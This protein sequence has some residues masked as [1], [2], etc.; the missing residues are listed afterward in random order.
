M[1]EEGIVDCII[2]LPTN[3]FSTVTIPACL[4]FL[5]KDCRN[6]GKTLFIDCREKGIMIDRKIREM[7]YNDVTIGH[8]DNDELI[9]KV[10]AYNLETYGD[11]N[12][13]DIESI[14]AVYHAW[15]KGEGYEDVMGF[16]KSATIEEIR[17]ADYS[18]VPG[19]Y[20]GIDDSGKMTEEEINAEIKRV[21]LELRELMEKGKV[22]DA[23]IY[24]I[25][26]SEE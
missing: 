7:T 20:V 26:D 4:W 1:L 10:K 17:E 24:E 23:K 8:Q 15:L 25:L 16:C 13:G 2:A 9:E 12:K 6:K 14:A 11:E 19:R 21:K 18:L 3:L 22:L 5:R